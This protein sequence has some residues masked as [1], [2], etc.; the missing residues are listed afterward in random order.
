MQFEPNRNIII[1][2]YI[3]CGLKGDGEKYHRRTDG[4]VPTIRVAILAFL[5]TKGIENLTFLSTDGME[6]CTFE[7]TKGFIGNYSLSFLYNF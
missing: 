5:S 4:G 2:I 1:Y 7:S 3:F 6:N